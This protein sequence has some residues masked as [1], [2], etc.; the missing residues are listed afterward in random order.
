TSFTPLSEPIKGPDLLI[1]SPPPNQRA[2]PFDSRPW[3]R[4]AAGHTLPEHAM[5]PSM[6]AR[7]RPSLAVD[8]SGSV[9]PAAAFRHR[10]DIG[11]VTARLC[12]VCRA[13]SKG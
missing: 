3:I 6:G 13:R 9:C 4:V 7:L 5:N 8:G 10:C 11:K 12:W 1:F 2:R